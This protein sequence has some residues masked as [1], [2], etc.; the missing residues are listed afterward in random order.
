[1]FPF[2]DTIWLTFDL[3]L[4]SVITL[5]VYSSHR[6]S[7]RSSHRVMLRLVEFWSLRF[8]HQGVLSSDDH[9]PSRTGSQVTGF[10]DLKLPGSVL[11][12]ISITRVSHTLSTPLPFFFSFVQLT[13]GRRTKQY[14]TV[15][16]NLPI[17]VT[18]D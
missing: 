9:V 10:S 3:L 6:G 1:M 2:Q 16:G 17:D 11:L 15:S 7:L 4:F 13:R 18:F 8:L 14:R 5:R 12:F